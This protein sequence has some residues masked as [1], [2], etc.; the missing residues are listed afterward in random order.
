MGKFSKKT[1]YRVITACF[2]A[3]IVLFCIV[4]Y[5]L[6]K[7]SYF[8]NTTCGIILMLVIAIFSLDKKLER[9]RWRRS[10]WIAWFGMC[11][12]FSVSDVIVPKKVCGLGLVLALVFTAVFFVWQNHSRRDLL[13]K[14]FK[15]A[16]RYSFWI[17]AAVSFL[18]RPLYEGGRYA[19]IFTNPNTFALYLCT[20]FSVFISDMDWCLET[21]KN[22][23]KYIITY[24]SLALVFFYLNLS[25]ARTSLIAIGCAFTFWVLVRLVIAKKSHNFMPIIKRIFLLVLSCAVLYPVYYKALEWIPAWINHPI[26]FQGESLYLSNGSMIKDLSEVVIAEPDVMEPGGMSIDDSAI[27][28]AKIKQSMEESVKEIPNSDQ[29]Q[30]VPA[31]IWD[32][33]FYVLENTRGLNSL[34]TG[35]IDIYKGYMSKLNY[36]GHKNVSL[37]VNG[38]KKA[39]A[40]N[41]WL[42]FGYTYGGIGML[43]YGIITVLGLGFS[44]KFYIKNRRRD[45][46]YAFM[47]PAIMISFV[48]ATIAECLFLPF[49]VFPAFAFWFAFCDLFVKKGKKKKICEERENERS[50]L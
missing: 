25:Q 37:V 13:W 21:E 22:S 40:H 38:K 16:V 47:I 34:T 46:S 27:N 2:F 30:V 23:K 48:V 31:G 41:N 43:F 8:Y 20:I 44:L 36:A 33:F 28:Q 24:L 6:H 4:R 11:I 19:G 26:I 35:R 12:S 9:I 42:Q 10:M 1:K 5:V 17:M 49:E 45:A 39:H 3:D 29:Q 15:D 7:E 18:F 50:S 32:R 14:C